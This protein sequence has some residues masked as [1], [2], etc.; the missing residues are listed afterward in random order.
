MSPRTPAP[1]GLGGTLTALMFGLASIVFGTSTARAAEGYAYVSPVPGSALVSPWNNVAIRHGAAID[2][3]T[4]D[5]S[6]LAVV[7]SVSGR[8]AGDLVLADDSRTLVFEPRQPYALG[9]TVHVTLA[10]GPRTTA[11]Q[12][13][14]PLSFNFT[15]AGAAPVAPAPAAEDFDPGPPR[16]RTAAATSRPGP[17]P[18]AAYLP[19]D[20]PKIT[21]LTRDRPEPGYIFVSPRTDLIPAPL[22]I[23]DN[24]AM[25]IFYRRAPYNLFDF[26]M[27]P[28]GRLS[29]Y[30]P[31]R[32]RTYLMDSTYAVVDS[33]SAGNGYFADFHDFQLLPNGHA[34][35]ICYNGQAVDMDTVVAGGDPEA[36]VIGCVV[37]EIDA[38]KKVVFQWRSWDHF[39]ITDAVDVD[40]TASTI[41]YVHANAVEL[42]TDGNLLLSCRNMNE[43]TKIN[44]QTGAI[45]WRMGPH[46]R[47][48]QFRFSDD[49][50][51]FGYQHDARRLPNGHITLFDNGNFLNPQTTRAV[52]Y[53]V[54]EQARTARLVWEYDPDTPG[55]A[56]SNGSVQRRSSGGTMIGWG[57][58]SVVPS[59]TDLHADGSKALELSVFATTYRAFR[60]PW[61]TTRFVT[62][63]KQLDFGGVRTGQTGSLPL[64]ITNRTGSSVKLTR[65]VSL[66]SLSFDV[67]EPPPITITPH[68]KT[69]VHVRFSP[70]SLGDFSTTVYLRAE[71]DSEIIAQDVQVAGKGVTGVP[72]VSVVSPNGGEQFTAGGALDLEWSA[73]QGVGTTT[74]DLMLSRTGP[75]GPFETIALSVANTGT[76]SWQLGTPAT[77]QAYL[78][79]VSHD[80]AG[81]TGSDLSD[82]A[83]TILPH[84]TG[85]DDAPPAD[86]MLA[87]VSPNPSTRGARIEYT[88]ARA[89]PVR[90]SVLDLSGRVI[91]VL[92][93]GVR[94]PGRYRVSWPG[95]DGHRHVP[96]GIYLVRYE[97]AGKSLVQRIVM[98]Q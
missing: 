28:N 24:N 62:D 27:Q 3:A 89:V 49:P 88:V 83:F 40:L 13:L 57:A 32:W 87:P 92:A 14:P 7:G 69:T 66:D 31:T 78:K 84:N 47:N 33:F 58:G 97:A 11:G 19:A 55:F 18:N 74:V 72:Q 15:V 20:Y 73:T 90:L 38:A 44:R 45:I 2:P 34:L 98:T 71:K 77:N 22:V 8:H 16:G 43:V 79:V 59:V 42:D 5:A 94:A 1:H 37:Q 68:G 12:S 54:D 29:Y 17:A 6:A 50:R 60:H 63:T 52:E 56:N 95:T 51:G 75:G 36:S 26:K 48:N 25:P 91:A 65:F 46:A 93:D 70:D 9:E 10:R 30:D 76:Y 4:I 67:M 86:F 85:V 41:D 39:R 61:Q 82:S 21:L 64:M 35:L 80:G 53:E 96:P 23:L 81:S